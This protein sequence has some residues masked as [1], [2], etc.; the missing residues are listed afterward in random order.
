MPPRE[1]MPRVREAAERALALDDSLAPAHTC[2]AL[3][4]V[5]YD[6]DFAKGEA[7]FRR[8]I[9]L[10]P[11]DADAHRMYGDFLAAMGRFDEA[12]AE[13]RRAEQLD[14]LSV[15]ASWD[16]GRTSLS[17][18]AATKRR[19]S[20]PNTRS[21]SIPAF[22]TF[23]TS[24]RRSTIAKNNLPEALALMQKAMQLGGH[25]QLLITN[26][27][28]INARAGNRDEA[29]R[30]MDE[31]R[32]R[33]VGTYTLPLFLARIYAALGNNDEAMK[34]LEQVYND[35]S[36]SA[37]W[38]KVDPSLETLRNDPRFIALIRKVGLTK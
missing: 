35:R 31:L 28:M 13:K 15:P 12:I 38:L 26:W 22:L 16:V 11:N 1:A 32:A 33:A 21:I 5:W 3:A 30:A 14:P 36:E 17:T 4:L 20:R 24:R 7:E 2:L 27:G 6:W 37:V 23:T 9:A 18:P 19:S 29:L 10:N 8:A 34:N 25:T